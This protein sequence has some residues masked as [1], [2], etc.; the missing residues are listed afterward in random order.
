MTEIFN[1]LSEKEKKCLLSNNSTKAEEMLWG[2]LKNK[3]IL[4]QRYLRQFSIGSYVVDFYCPKLRLVLE[5]DGTTHSLPEE[6]E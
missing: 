4:G 3:K 2:E 5:V 6:I 1:K